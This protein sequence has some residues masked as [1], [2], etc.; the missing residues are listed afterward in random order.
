[1]LALKAQ[2][3]RCLAALCT[4]CALLGCAGGTTRPNVVLVIIDTLRADKLGAYGFGEA[5]S[6]AFD[7][8]AA[9]GVLFRNVL[10]ASSWTRP[11][12]AALVT[13]LPPRSLGIFHEYD[14]A[15]GDRFATLAEVLWAGGYRTLGATANPN[16]NRSYH[17]DQGF[18][19][20]SD[21]RVIF[22]WMAPEPG[23]Q[24]SEHAALPA[25]RDLYAALLERIAASE[26]RPFYVQVNVMEV[27]EHLRMRRRPELYTQ[28]GGRN[29]YANLFEGHPNADYLR[30]VR[31]ATDEVAAFIEAVSALPGGRNTLFIVTSDH[32]EGLGDHPHVPKAEGH[33]FV[34]YESQLRVP[35]L[36]YHPAR[37]LPQGRVVEHPVQLLD[38]M[39]SVLEFVGLE[40]PAGLEGRSLLPL[41]RGDTELELPDTYFAETRFQRR[42]KVA[43]YTAEWKYIENREPEGWLPPRTLHPAGVQEDGMH[44]DVADQHPDVV[45]RLAA[46]LRAWEAS[47]PA[48]EPTPPAVPPTELEHQQLRDLG[49][50]E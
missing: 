31:Q 16:I 21:S 12:I 44:T 6:P 14:D 11:S 45:E 19:E 38:V 18:D 8:L 10:A 13:G 47:H 40:G 46:Q 4:A 29:A 28:A 34:L 41:A 17:F 9:R 39:P 15:L 3:L 25:G 24:S 36:F 35:L 49:Y 27:H 5:T 42:D 37:A 43:A 32:G 30:S 26:H 23:A 1:M 20:Y 48:A 50:L 7:A 2:A 33:G 22:P